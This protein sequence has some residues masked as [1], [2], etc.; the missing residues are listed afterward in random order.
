MSSVKFSYLLDMGCCGLMDSIV[1]AEDDISEVWVR[2]IGT[3]HDVNI[4]S[5]ISQKQLDAMRTKLKQVWN[6]EKEEA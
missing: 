5:A 2:F 6:E 4:Y 1:V 3:Y